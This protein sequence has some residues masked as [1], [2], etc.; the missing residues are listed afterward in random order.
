MLK[1]CIHRQYNNTNR[2]L[3][4]VTVLLL[5]SVAVSH[6]P[7]FHRLEI[8]RNFIYINYNLPQIDQIYN[9]YYTAVK[10]TPVACG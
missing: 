3:Y 8:A 6:F 2:I 5:L 9:I 10:D 4:I 7:Q 1:C